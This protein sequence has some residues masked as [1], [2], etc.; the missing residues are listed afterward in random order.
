VAQ[1]LGLTETRAALAII[2]IAVLKMSLAVRQVSVE[3]GYDPRD[4]AMV[5]FGGAGPLHAADVAR[6]LHIPT[7]IVPTFPGQFSAAGMLLADLRHDYVRTYYSPLDRA[8]FADLVAIAAELSDTARRTLRGERATDEAIRLALSLDVRYA[9]QDASMTVPIE[10]HVLERA[11][12]RAVMAKF[13]DG[14]Q[15]AFGYQNPERPLELVSVRLAASAARRLPPRLLA[16]GHSGATLGTGPTGT[17][18]VWF[19]GDAAVDCPVYWRD[20]LAGGTELTGPAVVQ[21]YAST[22]LVFP[23]DR[24]EVAATG[25][26]RIQIG[27]AT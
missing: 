25:E 3:R 5:A 22:T 7:I 1:P 10:P 8:N 17:H 12:R 14:H 26:L 27:R 24:L 21:E 15:R 13:N 19:S 18:R 11:D 6:A 23:G 9:G 4:F 2:E 16:G 20:T